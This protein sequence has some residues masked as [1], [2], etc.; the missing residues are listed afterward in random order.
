MSETTLRPSTP[1]CTDEN[2]EVKRPGLVM[3]PPGEGLLF[4]CFSFC[5]CFERKHDLMQGLKVVYHV[6]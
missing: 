2:G 4:H 3:F 1:W 5:G 6:D